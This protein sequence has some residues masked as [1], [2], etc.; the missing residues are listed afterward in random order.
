MSTAHQH[1]TALVLELILLTNSQFLLSSRR[2][3]RAYRGNVL[4]IAINGDA[5]PHFPTIADYV[6][7]SRDTITVILGQVLIALS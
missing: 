7:R 4:L 3:E 5:K 2:N 6:N 1:S